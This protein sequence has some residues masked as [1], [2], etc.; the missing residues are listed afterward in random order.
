M[1]GGLGVMCQRD[2]KVG[3]GFSGIGLWRIQKCRNDVIFQGKAWNPTKVIEVRRKHVDE[4]RVLVNEEWDS[5]D[6]TKMNR[7]RV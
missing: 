4:Y 5:L 2:G 7:V 6:K 3:Q 1:L